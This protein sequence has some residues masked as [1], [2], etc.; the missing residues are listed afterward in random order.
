LVELIAQTSTLAGIT[1]LA[2]ERAVS[3]CY[4]NQHRPTNYSLKA[5]ERPN[6]TDSL[7][8]IASTSN[9][10]LEL[11]MAEAPRGRDIFVN[12]GQSPAQ[13]G[14]LFGAALEV[15]PSGIVS[16]DASRELWLEAYGQPRKIEVYQL[17]KFGDFLFK[18]AIDLL[19]IPIDVNRFPGLA[20]THR[21]TIA[22][23]VDEASLKN[24]YYVAFPDGSVT[25]H[26][27]RFDET[28]ESYGCFL[29][30]AQEETPQNR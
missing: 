21:L 17:E 19:D 6:C 8:E 12:G 16:E 22:W 2:A 28:E 18:L 10:G 27:L 4:G 24:D 9:Q 11:G 7:R 23:A 15:Q 5:F 3:T 30:S 13:I 20:S 1:P 25:V 14:A 29:G 26:A